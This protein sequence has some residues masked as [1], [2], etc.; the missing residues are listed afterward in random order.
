[1]YFADYKDH[2]ILMPINW[3]IFKKIVSQNADSHME[4]VSGRA[5]LN[6]DLNF[7]HQRSSFEPA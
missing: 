7:M 5:R 1:M 4:I 2:L 3:R 6:V